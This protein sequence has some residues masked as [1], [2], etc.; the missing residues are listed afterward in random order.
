M[1]KHQLT[2]SPDYVLDWTYVQAARELFQNALD[3][4]T[5]TPENTM[6]FNYEKGKLQIGNKTSI[7]TLDTL[8]L[9][10]SSKRG[11]TKTIGKHGEGYKVALMVLLREGKQVTIYNYG[12]KEVWRTRLVKSRKFNGAL[13]TEIDVDKKHFWQSVPSH[14][15][16]IEVD[17]ISEEE[18]ADIVETNLH[19]SDYPT[20]YE[21]LDGKEKL[22]NILLDEDKVGKVYI[23]GL[24]VSS[25]DK[26]KFGYDIQP[27]HISLDRD[28]KL[29]DSFNLAWM[30]SKMWRYVNQEEKVAQMLLA[31]VYDVE[32]IK[33]RSS[34]SAN[35]ESEIDS[36]ITSA[37]KQQF[38]Y[39]HGSKSIA[40]SSNSDLQKV[41]TQ[42]KGLKPVMVSDSVSDYFK[43]SIEDDSP[44]YIG[45][46]TKE[47]LEDW[48]EGVKSKLSDEQITDFEIIMD[49]MSDL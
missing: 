25:N 10:S 48:F 38:S 26:F 35:T 30:T 32:F 20:N 34:S 21:V 47:C 43:D 14:S 16:V 12:A 39:T 36:K 2:I 40:V 49:E 27:A 23:N 6:F 8:L 13:I 15:L 22:G 3:N 9:G 45:K 31:K 24:Y 28:R 29:I 5:T 11:D 19:L 37:L 1:A 4:E 46:S 7:L 17:G 42:G 41:S 44:I 18:Y 33:S